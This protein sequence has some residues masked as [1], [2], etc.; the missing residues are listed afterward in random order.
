MRIDNLGIAPKPWFS[1]D[2]AGI[3]DADG[4]HVATVAITNLSVVFDCMVAERI[5]S[6][7]NGATLTPTAAEQARE[8]LVVAAHTFVVAYDEF[9]SAAQDDDADEV[10]AMMRARDALVRAVR[11]YLAAQPQVPA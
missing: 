9:L 8:A 2:I 7:V 3:F 1:N 4:H 5:V 11:V 10:N 6:A